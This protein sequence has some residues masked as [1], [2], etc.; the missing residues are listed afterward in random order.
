MYP[1][2][3]FYDN[4]NIFIDISIIYCFRVSCT[5]WVYKTRN[6]KQPFCAEVFKLIFSHP[7]KTKFIQ[8]RFI[9]NTSM[10]TTRVTMFIIKIST[11]Y[12]FDSHIIIFLNIYINYVNELSTE[13]LLFCYYKIFIKK[14][15]PYLIKRK[16]CWELLYFCAEV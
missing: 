7:K 8:E 10:H 16:I 2:N 13:R 11:R 15:N 9:D 14:I 4:Q 5:R 3:R 12:K 1:V 6:I